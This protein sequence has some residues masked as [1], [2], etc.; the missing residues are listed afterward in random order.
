VVAQDVEFLSPRGSGSADS[1]YESDFDAAPK[2]AAQ[3]PARKKATLQSFDD[4][5][6]IPF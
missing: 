1:G 5:S 6:D 3:V 4:D 2:S